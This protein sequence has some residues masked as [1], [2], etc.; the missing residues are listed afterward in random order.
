MKK[1]IFIILLRLTTVNAQ[2]GILSLQ[3]SIEL[4]LNNSKEI[5]ISMSDTLISDALVTNAWSNLLPQISLGFTYNHISEMPIQLQLPFLPASSGEVLNAMYSNATIE[6][7]LFT[8]F[9]LLAVKNAAFYNKKATVMEN[10][11]VKNNKALEINFAFWNYFKAIKLV[12][13]LEENLKVVSLQVENVSNFNKNEMSSE[14]DLLK[15]K[16]KEAEIKSK[17]IEAQNQMKLAKANFNRVI[18][19]NISNNTQIIPT[20]LDEKIIEFDFNSL[21]NEAI[22]SNIDLTTNNYRKKAADEKITIAKSSWFPQISA[23]GSYYYLQLSGSSMLNDDLNNFWMVGINAKWNI[24]D[25][26]KTSSNADVAIQEYNKIEIANELL[27]EKI[28]LEVYSNLLN[29]QSFAQKIELNKLIVESASE[30]FR[31]TNNKF[32]SQIVTATELT[33]ASAI[34]TEAKIK[35][36]NSQIDYKLGLL[37]LYNSIGRKIY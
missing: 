3:K 8:G 33:E 36:I 28:Q 31:I 18:G 27:K 9:K 32:E 6:Q 25:W 12:D 2:T 16:V 10:N 24:W 26:W 37:Q 20:D 21:L 19:L 7:P 15:I 17:I 29:L 5:K 1:I 13:I 4:G 35:L 23:F 34:L 22:N 11:K 14:N 30:N